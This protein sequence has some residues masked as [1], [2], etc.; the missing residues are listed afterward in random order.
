MRGLY[1][2]GVMRNTKFFSLRAGNLLITFTSAFLVLLFTYTGSIKLINHEEFVTQLGQ[3]PLVTNFA[4]PISWFIP[5]FELLIA[6]MLVVPKFQLT[7]LYLSLFLL[8]MFTGYIFLVLKFSPTVP[9]SCGGIIEKMS[10][11]QH[12]GFNSATALLTTIAIVISEYRK[13]HFSE[14]FI[15]TSNLKPGEAEN[16]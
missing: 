12:L 4:L 10:W 16:L 7:A 15:Q 11:N 14:E 6:V 13:K 8:L 1:F 5:V 3:S 2:G 9:C